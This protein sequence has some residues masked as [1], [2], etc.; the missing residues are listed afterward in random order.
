MICFA[1]PS[2]LFSP[3][4]CASPARTKDMHSVLT[5][6]TTGGPTFS[7]GRCYSGALPSRL[8]PPRS[9]GLTNTPKIRPD[10]R[11]GRSGLR[12]TNI[13]V[14]G[15]FGARH[16]SHSEQER[17]EN[18]SDAHAGRRKKCGPRG[19]G[20]IAFWGGEGDGMEGSKKCTFKK[21]Y[22]FF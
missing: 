9:G 1:Q 2:P 14:E 20:P 16:I 5:R 10:I 6:N 12:I 18:H 4:M 11:R 21:F 3:L 8:L 7:F 22:D 19:H 17:R 13:L 15:G